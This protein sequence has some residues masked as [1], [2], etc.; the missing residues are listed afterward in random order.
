MLSLLQPHKKITILV[1]EFGALKSCAYSDDDILEISMWLDSNDLTYY[2]QGQAI[3]VIIDEM[4]V[5]I[6]PTENDYLLNIAKH[7]EVSD[8]VQQ[9]EKVR[10]KQHTQSLIINYLFVSIIGLT[11][12]GTISGMVSNRDNSKVFTVINGLS[13]LL[14]AICGYYFSES[15]KDG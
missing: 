5:D 11:V 14:A 9:V 2:L 6:F 3:S 13:P 7:V 12:L 10:G 8:L 1:D 15:K 4:M